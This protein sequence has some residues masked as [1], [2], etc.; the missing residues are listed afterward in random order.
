MK[1]LL[2][3]STLLL[4]PVAATAD[5]GMW[6]LNNFP[7]DRVGAKYGFSP[8]KAWLDDVRL[9]SVRLAGG[10]SASFVSPDGLVMTNHHCSHSC[11][12]Q[13]STPEKDYVAGGFWAK[14]AADEVRCPEIEVNQLTDI[15]D[16]TTRVLGATEGLSGEAY[17]AAK[18]AVTATIEKEC[19][20]SDDVRCDVISLY[21]GG[22]YDLYKYGRFQDV[23]LVFAPELAIA[24][25]GG[26]PDNF[27]FPRYDL[28]CSFLRVYKDGKPM[29]VDHYFKWSPSGAT[30]GDLTFVSGHPGGT[31]RLLTV[32][33]LEYE[34]DKALPDALLQLAEL[35]GMLRE[36]QERGPEQKRIST[37]RLFGVENGFKGL[38]GRL[39]A[40]QDKSLIAR[41]MSEEKALREKI[42]AM[43]DKQ[44]AYGDAWD[45]IAKAI[46]EQANIQKSLNYIEGGR[47]FASRLYGLAQALVRVSSESLVPNEKRLPEFT[48]ANLPAVK[49]RLASS[50][51]IYD[52]LEIATLTFSL[53][54]LREELRADNPFVRK[55]LGPKSP[56]ELAAELVHGTALKDPAVRMKLY[57]GGKAAVDASDDA[58]IRFARLIDPDARA[59]RKKYED[60][61]E[62]VLNK[63]S[64]LVA[65]AQ[66]D[67]Y[68]SGTYPDATFTLRLSYGTVAGYMEDGKPVDPVTHMAGAFAR[69]T[70]RAPFALPQ[71][72]LDAKPKLDL[73]TPMNFATT[74][75]IIGGNSGSPVIDRDARIVGLIFDG[76]IQSLGGDYGFDEAVN[77]SVAVHSEA[78]I[79][80]L[81]KVYNARRLVDELRPPGAGRVRAAPDAR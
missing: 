35:R 25:F 43:P 64:E 49:Q 62:S 40:L 45:A 68:G 58:M 65:R 78:L 32:A 15:T 74:N 63:N 10:C 21:H 81:D 16:V 48:E 31:S 57:L 20:V 34:R 41:K 23:R 71:S 67:A 5:E 1:R 53:T 52:E 69:H 73:D 50:A 60:E 2:V 19:A 75:D 36:F 3:F 27:M 55:V 28:D 70:G 22:R 47:G 42:A 7:S 54:K 14:T 39:E 66:F 80:A 59:V 13:L 46:V 29:K 76:N 72:W 56:A 12:Q 6:T 33:E 26:D 37:A 18:K 61:I 17:T 30:G 77:R 4:F 24:F 11:I 51:P 9:A 79:Q 8:T 44:K 38:R